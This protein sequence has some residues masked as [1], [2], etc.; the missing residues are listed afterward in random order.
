MDD[1]GL[2]LHLQLLETELHRVAT[3]QNRA[4]LEE[5]LHADFVELARTG[6]RYSRQEVLEEFA[7]GGA[8]LE[9]VHSDQFELRKLSPGC[10]LLIYRSAHKRSNGELHR[11]TLRSSVWVTT[12][13]GWQML[14]HQGTAAEAA[15]APLGRA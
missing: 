6:R 7:P 2:L 8:V 13:R 9:D 15:A 10:A 3:R 1:I 11:F 12:E 5:L 14:F 4:R